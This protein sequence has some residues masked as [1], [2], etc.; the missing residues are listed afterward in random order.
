[1]RGGRLLGCEGAVLQ[2][3]ASLLEYRVAPKKWGM[4][5]AGEGAGCRWRKELGAARTHSYI[6]YIILL[7]NN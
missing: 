5:F 1:M 6:Y 2:T 4:H 7:D 3:N